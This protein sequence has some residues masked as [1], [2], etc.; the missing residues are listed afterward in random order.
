MKYKNQLPSLFF[1]FLF[2]IMLPFQ[3]FASTYTKVDVTLNNNSVDWDA[4][5][6]NVEGNVYVPI[7]EMSKAIGI[8]GSFDIKTL[9]Y[10]LKLEQNELEL[11]LDNSIA[12]INGKFVQMQGTM[13]IIDNRLMVPVKLFEQVG[14]LII[15][16]NGKI[17]VFKPE[18]GKIIY[19]VAWG[20]YFWKISQ[21][22]GTSISE[23]KTLN[24]LTSDSIAA[25]Q[26]LI[27]KVVLPFS[28]NFDAVTG[29]ATIKSG[30]G[31]K[32]SDVGYLASGTHVTVTGKEGLWFRVATLK[33]NGYIY[34]T[35]IK[36]TQNI[37][38]TTPVS[39][40]F[41][42]SIQ[43]D[44]SR[45]TLSYVDYKVFSGDTLWSVSEKMGIPVEEVARVN[46]LTTSSY[47]KINQILKIPFHTIAQKEMI[48]EQEGEV[49]DWFTEGQYVLPITKTAKV[50]DIQTGFSFN[51]ERTMG[52]SHSDTETL[53][54]QD[55]QV[56][57][58]I[59]GGTWNWTRRPFILE[60]DG[61][62]FAVSIA[63]MPHAG[64]EGLPFL[65][66][67]SNRSD[68]YGYGPNYDRISGNQMDGHFDLYFLNGLRHVDN[69][70]DPDHQKM[71]TI[72]GGLR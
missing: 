42:N 67:V 70:I 36:V 54:A 15:D 61:R 12:R 17:L 34:N 48:G 10:S 33:G 60:V 39:T 32:F 69:K 62:R 26:S 27:V 9:V 1:A 68:N 71:V 3:C 6:V 41:Q 51:I 40:Y 25:G 14:M 8:Q 28:T 66:N 24:N 23:I 38:D 21:M 30:A 65:Q 43:V 13:K 29:N 56:M 46:G 45:D 4:N 18:N 19:K 5:P 55:T 37:I 50:T 58:Q 47:L 20:D 72:A 64:V 7:A 2:L 35:V 53:T 16:K 44:T 52:S 11:K 22:F 59:F 49:L 31:F 57:K 63:G